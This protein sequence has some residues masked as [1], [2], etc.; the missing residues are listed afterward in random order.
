MYNIDYESGAQT[1][2]GYPGLIL[3]AISCSA[4]LHLN[5]FLAGIIEAF[6]KYHYLMFESRLWLRRNLTVNGRLS[7]TL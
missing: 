2:L 1:K 5:L 3:N 4:R 6:I 7:E